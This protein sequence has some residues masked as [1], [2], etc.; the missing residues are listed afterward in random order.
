MKWMFMADIKDEKI[1]FVLNNKEYL[2]NVY[3][4]L[5]DGLVNE[6]HIKNL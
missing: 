5:L 3:K 2:K 6:D 1:T 4:I